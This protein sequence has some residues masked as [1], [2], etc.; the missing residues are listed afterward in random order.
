M[1]FKFVGNPNDAR[2]NR[3]AIRAFGIM[4]P[5]NVSVDVTDERAC[6]KLMGNG[7][8]VIDDGGTS[9]HQMPGKLILPAGPAVEH[10]VDD[11]KAMLAEKAASLGIDVDRRWGAKRIQQAI[12]EIG[13]AA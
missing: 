6:R 1:H 10:P 13:G 7:H 9:F 8:F 2:D 3:G 4:F 11:G 12:D 5:L